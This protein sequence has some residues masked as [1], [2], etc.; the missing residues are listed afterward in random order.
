[1]GDE[2]PRRRTLAWQTLGWALA[3]GVVVAWVLLLQAPETLI[4]CL[5]VQQQRADLCPPVL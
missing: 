4:P 2:V 3:V 5:S 1:M